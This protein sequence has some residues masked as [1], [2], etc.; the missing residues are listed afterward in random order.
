MQ[1]ATITTRTGTHY[2][3]EHGILHSVI[4]PGVE[5]T[6]ADAQENVRIDRQLGAGRRRPLLVDIR[7]IKSQTS[8]ARDYYTGAEGA[9]CYS[10]VAVL[11]GS[12][13][14]RLLGNFF[15]GFNKQAFAPVK[16]FTSE[17]EAMA[18]LKTFRS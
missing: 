5:Q 6:L 15:I 17:A 16:L 8:E 18:W 7:A 13:I 3:N 11:I 2:L 10:A 14:S 4:L 12:P 9:A 1:T